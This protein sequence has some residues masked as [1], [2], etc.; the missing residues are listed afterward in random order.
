[1][2]CETGRTMHH[3]E[4]LISI[5]DRLRLS[6]QRHNKRRRREERKKSVCHQ[7]APAPSLIRD[8]SWPLIGEGEGANSQKTWK[9]RAELLE[10]RDGG[11]RTDGR[12]SFFP[13]SLCVAGCCREGENYAVIK[14]SRRGPAT[15]GNTHTHNK[16]KTKVIH[17]HCS[18]SSS[19]MISSST[20]YIY[21]YVVHTH[22]YIYSHKIQT[23]E[24]EAGS[25]KRR[26]RRNETR[27]RQ[28]VGDV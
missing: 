9:R 26:R 21:T 11:S 17:Q 23:G 5:D 7:K 28:T 4:S 25:Q 10:N 8:D 16:R 15:A 18:P 19:P 20:R 1:M 24:M 14:P 2:A 22:I 3:Q 12:L 13:L 6:R 27:E